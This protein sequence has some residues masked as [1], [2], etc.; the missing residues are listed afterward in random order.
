M[1]FQRCKTKN[2]RSIASWYISCWISRT[3]RPQSHGVL[4]WTPEHV[5]RCTEESWG[6]I[7]SRLIFTL[8]VE[9]CQLLTYVL[10]IVRPDWTKLVLL[11]QAVCSN[12]HTFV[13]SP[14]Y[15][16]RKYLIAACLSAVLNVA[17]T[18]C[19][20][21]QDRWMRRAGQSSKN[22]SVG[23][24]FIFTT[25]STDCC[26]IY[27]FCPHKSHFIENRRLIS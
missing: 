6:S 14:L 13:L 17:L 15:N 23:N 5:N 24:R 22:E 11:V 7:A 4:R 18:R 25:L 8:L 3:R 9:E 12:L 16:V 1:I 19:R 20:M 26:I 10:S 21:I 2:I 27:G